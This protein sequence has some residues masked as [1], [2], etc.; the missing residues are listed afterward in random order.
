MIFVCYILLRTPAKFFVKFITIPL[1]FFLF[2][3]TIYKLNDILGNA[4]PV[5]HV[6]K[7]ILLDGLKNGQT[8]E[9]WVKHLG[10]RDTR[11]YKLPWTKELQKKLKQGL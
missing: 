2:Y 4:Y 9:I 1:L 10:E 8:I 3:S 5:I 7:V 6:G 11:L